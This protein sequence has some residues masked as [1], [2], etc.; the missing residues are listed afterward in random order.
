[1]RVLILGA[2]GHA[3]V[4]ADILLRM[5]D[6]GSEVMP[7][8]FLDDDPGL[9]GCHYLDLP[10]LGTLSAL[11]K[12][13]RDAVL[14][15]I[16]DNP[17]RRRIFERLQERGERFAIACHPRAMI[18]PDVRIGPGSMISAGV[19]VNTGATI[20]ANVILNT[21]CTVDHHSRVGDH[22]HIA[23][24]VH[25]GG[26]V[27]I[28]EGCFVAIGSSVIPGRTVGP[29]SM[30]GVG[31]AVTKDIPSGVMAVGIPARVVNE[32]RVEGD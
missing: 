14:V 5:L 12:I 25:L 27:T 31:S 24:G 1:M 16:G 8:G 30:V 21:A 6:K 18:A 19:V 3:Q 20:G 9:V 29:W 11:D 4:V 15:G 17:T 7:I 2:G 10:V 22:A 32:L 28:G 13:P 23:P 26:E